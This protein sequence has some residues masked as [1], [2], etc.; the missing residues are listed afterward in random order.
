MSQQFEV[1][2][3][4]LV[5]SSYYVSGVHFGIALDYYGLLRRPSSRSPQLLTESSFGPCLDLHCIIEKYIPSFQHIQPSTA[6][7]YLYSLYIRPSVSSLSVPRSALFSSPLSTPVKPAAQRETSLLLIDDIERNN[8]IVRA[9]IVEL[10]VDTRDFDAPISNQ[11]KG[12][13]FVYFSEKEA[14]K[15]ICDAAGRAES[16]GNHY[17]AMHLYQLAQKYKEMIRVLLVEL[18]RVVSR[19][20]RDPDRQH[21]IQFAQTI[22][23]TSGNQ[24]EDVLESMR[25]LEVLLA[26]VK[27]YD[28]YYGGPS[29][30]DAALEVLESLNIIPPD[31]NDVHTYV[32]RFERFDKS[33]KSVFGNVALTCMEIFSEKA[34]QLKQEMQGHRQIYSRSTKDI[35]RQKIYEELKNKARA[36]V[37][38]AEMS[39][40]F[41]CS[42]SSEL[43]R[44]ETLM[45]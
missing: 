36:L 40:P 4:Y 6:F 35:S 5:R 22:P 16:N 19:E 34:R 32:E 25:N 8:E 29:T 12:Y 3:N 17:D 23:Q 18:S 31:V 24:G 44:L 9:S 11:K 41:I 45:A 42:V 15:I 27:Y 2:I 13:L 20:S 37:N 30:Y 21:F 39:Q 26:L 7:H 38:F 43:V 1:A 28:F 33:V 14:Q 10:I